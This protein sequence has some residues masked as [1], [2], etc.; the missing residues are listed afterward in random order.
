MIKIFFKTIW[1]QRSKNILILVEFFLIY[2]VL[3]NVSMYYTEL[4]AVRLIPNSYEHDH[5]VKITIDTKGWEEGSAHT[6]NQL[7]NLKSALALNQYVDEVSISTNAAPFIYSIGTSMFSYG[8]EQFSAARRN[9]DI[10]YGEVMKIHMLKGRWF[11]ESDRGKKVRPAIIDRDIEREYFDGDALSKRFHD[12]SYEVIGVV[13][14]FKRSDI[15][16]PYPCLFRFREISDENP[17]FY[18]DFL[19]RV[20]H[21]H[22]NDFL[23]VAGN[24]VFSVLNSEDWSMDSINTLENQRIE[25]NKSEG[26]R[27]L[28]I[29]LVIAFV[30]LN[31]VLGVIGILWYNTYLRIHEMGI[32]KAVGNYRTRIIREL[33]LEN[34]ILA[35]AGALPVVLILAQSEGLRVTPV[36]GELFLLS[37]VLSFVVMMVLVILC[38]VLPAKIASSIHPAVALKYE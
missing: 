28:V 21:G 38:S 27:R 34:I 5:V 23:D 2:L 1:N 19:I 11:N 16:R 37:Q 12:D 13:N 36:K 22:I 25:Q 29:I 15:E 6:P 26:T 30:V 33:V 7:L 4:T 8:E 32:K 18:V 31:I 10:E 24:E 3:A 14:P 35:L 20:S 9:T 17:E